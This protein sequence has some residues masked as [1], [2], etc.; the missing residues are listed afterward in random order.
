MK[1]PK[2]RAKLFLRQRIH[3]YMDATF[4]YYLLP[5]SLLQREKQNIFHSILSIVRF[6][7]LLSL[8]VSVIFNQSWISSFISGQGKIEAKFSGIWKSNLFLESTFLIALI[9]NGLFNLQQL[10]GW[11]ISKVIIAWKPSFIFNL[12]KEFHFNSVS[13]MN[14]ITSLFW[15]LIANSNGVDPF[16]SFASRKRFINSIGLLNA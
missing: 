12:L 7:P 10:W 9:V 6:V 2:L 14:N 3:H 11:Q 13:K 8:Q 16:L 5:K 4:Q 1:W 15:V